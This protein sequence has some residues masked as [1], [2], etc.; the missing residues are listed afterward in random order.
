MFVRC[1]LP[2][3]V[4][5]PVE[6]ER[7]LQRPSCRYA[8]RLCQ[9]PQGEKGEQG[10]QGIQGLKGAT[11]AKGATGVQGPKGDKGDKGD[12]GV[13]GKDGTDAFIIVSREE[14]EEG[15]IWFE[16]TE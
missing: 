9:G 7:H 1:E 16:V 2:L 3:N 11:G 14:P 12:P 6:L 15:N 13:D 5:H 4:D 8:T 10:P